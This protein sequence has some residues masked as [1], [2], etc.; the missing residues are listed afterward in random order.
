MSKSLMISILTVMLCVTTSI[1]QAAPRPGDVAYGDAWQAAPYDFQFGNH[2][3][4]HTQLK[5]IAPQGKP[6]KLSG[7]FY[8]IFTDDQ[9]VSLGTDTHSTLR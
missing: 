3:D 9:G 8:I 6:N 7:S 4:T 5:L 1:L 2:I